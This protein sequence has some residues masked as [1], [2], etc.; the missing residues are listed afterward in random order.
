MHNEVVKENFKIRSPQGSYP[1]GIK[2]RKE[3]K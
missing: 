2:G 3:R 1:V